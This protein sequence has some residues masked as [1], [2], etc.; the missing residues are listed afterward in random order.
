MSGAQHRPAHHAA[1]I[2]RDTVLSTMR[3]IGADREWS[4]DD[5]FTEPGR[6]WLAMSRNDL[7]AAMDK[8]VRAGQLVRTRRGSSLDPARFKLAP[9][10]PTVPQREEIPWPMKD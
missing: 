5:L 8:L 1:S 10:A 3:R 7:R 6:L 9:I 2:R 4:V